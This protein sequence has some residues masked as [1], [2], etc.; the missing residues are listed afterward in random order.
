MLIWGIEANQK[1][2]DY[3]ADFQARVT[4]LLTPEEIAL[5]EVD[6]KEIAMDLLPQE[7]KDVLNFYG[8]LR[9]QLSNATATYDDIEKLAVKTGIAPMGKGSKNID[10]GVWTSIG[11]GAYIRGYP[12]G[13]RQ[14]DVEV[15][16]PA[17]VNVKRD[18]KNRVVSLDDGTN[19]IE[20]TYDDS[21]GAN[22]LNSQYPVYRFKSVTITGENAETTMYDNK[23]WYIPS[24]SKVSGSYSRNDDPS[25]QE[26]NDR[27]KEGDDFIK[28]VKKSMSKKRREKI[29]K[30]KWNNLA[31]LKQLELGLKDL[32]GV[33]ELS[34]SW[35]E[36]DYSL[37]V[38]TVNSYVS[39]I[40]SGN[41]KGGSS[42]GLTSIDLGGLV[43]APA[44]TSNQRLGV[45][46]GGPSGGHHLMTDIRKR[47]TVT[48]QL[49]SAV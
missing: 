35:E 2:S 41:K 4:P 34:G 40:S 42:N 36:N 20:I 43:F 45:G 3:P 1:F 37:A 7:V 12:H 29:K 25:V 6:T 19:K 22:A 28:S 8:N 10:A 21:P 17:N 33:T 48:R 5:M 16:I 23:G 9:A 46:N 31:D 27:K 38:N 26:Y 14:T 32:L 11:N 39:E 47:I 18:E 15:Y 30:D 24:L 13:Y 49:K 44:N